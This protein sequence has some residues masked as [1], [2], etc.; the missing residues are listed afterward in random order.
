MF[1]LV[2]NFLNPVQKMIDTMVTARTFQLLIVEIGK[3]KL[4]PSPSISTTGKRLEGA[5]VAFVLS[6]DDEGD[7]P[8]SAS[9]E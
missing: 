8:D 3:L 1:Y 5:V 7:D 9:S 2:I 6:F 4:R